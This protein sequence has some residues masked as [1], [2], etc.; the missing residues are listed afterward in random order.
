VQI[1][2][3]VD[4][5]LDVARAVNFLS[6]GNPLPPSDRLEPND[7]LRQA[8]KLWGSRPAFDATLDFWDDPVDVYSFRLGRGERLIVRLRGPKS[9]NVNLLLWKPGTRRVE[10]F[11]ADRR[12]LAAQSQSPDSIERW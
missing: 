1:A 4:L 6:S 9:A 3:V 2:R 10:G 12:L 7:A 5:H 11:A 8:R